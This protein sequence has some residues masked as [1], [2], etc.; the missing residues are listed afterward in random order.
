MKP[1][2]RQR[3]RASPNVVGAA[4]EALDTTAIHQ[5]DRAGL[6]AFAAE[7]CYFGRCAFSCLAAT[8]WPKKLSEYQRGRSGESAISRAMR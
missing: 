8:V 4:R 3:H 1:G 5:V 2:L 7:R 6:T